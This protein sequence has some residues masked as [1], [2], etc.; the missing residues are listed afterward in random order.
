VKPVAD[1]TTDLCVGSR[2][3]G[4]SEEL[5]INVSQ[6]FRSIGN[7]SMNIAINKRF[8]VQLSDTLN[9]FRAIRRDVGLGLGLVENTHTIEHEMVIRALRL[10]YRVQ[11][12]PVHE[13]ARK[14]GTSHIRIWR[15]WPY[16]VWCLFRHLYF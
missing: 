15:E 5:A 2:F 3:L 9:G 12:I 13:F 8:G 14:H 16:F 10:G 1:G 7:I 6:L 4:G 11:N